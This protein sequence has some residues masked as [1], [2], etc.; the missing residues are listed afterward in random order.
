MIKRIPFVDVAICGNNVQLYEALHIKSTAVFSSIS[1]AGRGSYQKRQICD[2][3]CVM[4]SGSDSFVKGAS[5]RIL[6]QEAGEALFSKCKYSGEM[7]GI[8]IFVLIVN[9]GVFPLSQNSTCTSKG[10]RFLDAYV[11][12]LNGNRIWQA[13]VFA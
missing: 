3:L 11:Y 4:L 10:I 12:R 8:A 2:T 6:V 13:E 7:L 9:H 1:E 5:T